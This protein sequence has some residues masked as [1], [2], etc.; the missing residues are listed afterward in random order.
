MFESV[1]AADKWYAGMADAA[2]ERG[3]VLQ[4]CLPSVTDILESLKYPAVV[5]ARA[6]NDYDNEV[7]NPFELGGSSLVMGA[8]LIAPSKDTLWTASPQPPTYN[9]EK[10]N[11]DYVEQP[12]VQLDSMLATLSLGPVGISDGLGQVGVDLIS[13]AFRSPTDS[14]LLRP[15]RP[16]S[17][18]DSFFYNRSFARGAAQDIRSTHSLVPLQR[19]GGALRCCRLGR[20]PLDRGQISPLYH[21]FARS[22]R[23]GGGW[24][25][26]LFRGR[27]SPGTE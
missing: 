26:D 18:V 9:D 5:Q 25:I 20:G 1:Y 17:W 3:L 15:A 2:F 8:L 10:Q 19:G 4:Y 16:L 13:Q 7:D 27:P 12:H 24:R 23:G 21:R 6:S 14:T 22:G 11:A